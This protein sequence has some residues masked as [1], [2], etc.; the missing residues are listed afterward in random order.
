[1]IQH[2]ADYIA[3]VWIAI[4]LLYAMLSRRGLIDSL[5]TIT[6]TVLVVP[7]YIAVISRVLY[8]ERQREKQSV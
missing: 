6:F 3:I 4:V 2:T 8:E 1:M 7:I 5:L